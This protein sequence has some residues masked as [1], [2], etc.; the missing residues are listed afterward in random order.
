MPNFETLKEAIAWFNNIPPD[1]LMFD[2][3]L[4]GASYLRQELKLV[5]NA[6]VE[7]PDRPLRRLM[8]FIKDYEVERYD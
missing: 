4:S 3:T 6:Q 2:V 7:F 5:G 8:D 1:A